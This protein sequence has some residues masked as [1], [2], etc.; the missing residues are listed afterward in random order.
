M[1]AVLVLGLSAV[2]GVV[3]LVVGLLGAVVVARHRAAS[4]ADLAALAAASRSLD[5]GGRACAA[6]RDVASDA[7]AGVADCRLEGDTAVVTA[8]V[9][10]PAALRALRMPGGMEVRSTARAG[11]AGGLVETGE[12]DDDPDRRQRTRRAPGRVPRASVPRSAPSRPKV[13][14]KPRFPLRSR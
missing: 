3:V 13:P 11:P 14:V 5:G 2:L 9:P 6:A 4:A 8:T 12:Q 10:A 7:G 1:A